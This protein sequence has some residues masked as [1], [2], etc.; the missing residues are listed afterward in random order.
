L[1]G[2]KEE[3]YVKPGQFQV[4]IEYRQGVEDEEENIVDT[5]E[6]D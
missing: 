2:S 4:G 5:K 6:R 1:E 3:V